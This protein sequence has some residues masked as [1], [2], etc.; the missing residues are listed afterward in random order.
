[1]KHRTR[2]IALPLLAM[3][4]G[5]AAATSLSAQADKAP[6]SAP[7]SAVTKVPEKAKA[8]SITV[9]ADGQTVYVVGMIFDG[10]FHQFDA[11]LLKAP[12]ARRVHLSSAGGYTLEARLMA[13]LVRKRKLDTYVETYCASAC[14]QVFAAGKSRVLGPAA[15]LGFHEASLI[16]D[17]SGETITRK[18]TDRKLTA[19]TVFGINGNDTLRLAYE[20]IG[21]DPAFIDKALSQSHE[22]MW[23]P[24]HKELIEARVVTR[25]A[26]QPEWPIPLGESGSRDAVR[27]RL[28][29][30]PL[31]QVALAK[32][33][34]ATE[35]AIDDAWRA[36][37]SGSSF[38]EATAAGRS[39]LV[40]FV[41]KSLAEATDPLLDRSL[42][43]YANSA[44]NERSRG[45]PACKT[46]LG[47]VPVPSETTD[48]MFVRLEDALLIDF[49]SSP[50][51]A[52]R[53]D[54]DE[55]TRYFTKEVIP[56]IAPLF[57]DGF[58]KGLTGKCKMGLQMFEAIDAMPKKK[59]VKSYRAL[60]SL[61]GMSEI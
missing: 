39:R 47:I 6:V 45:Y 19:T 31:W 51:R 34:A 17:S 60:L 61:P 7:T 35:A 55:A 1:M 57:G 24:T 37:N 33:P 48:L 50:Q 36:Y 12:Q 26:G 49:L 13:S 29:E 54:G 52:K 44:R 25:V 46:E 8:A 40:V 5:I 32:V 14:T 21:T 43:L 38:E 18:R 20:L 15:Q 53:M 2:R 28:L 30:T 23:L 11:V 16:D 22:S 58:A 59:R 42:T 10:T 4:S 41:T 56:V 9:S 3:I 27:I